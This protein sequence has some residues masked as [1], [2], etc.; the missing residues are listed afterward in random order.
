MLGSGTLGCNLARGLL[1]WGIRH[2]TF[3]DCGNISISNP[4]R[5]SLYT[6][7]DSGKSKAEAAAEA[8]KKI[9]PGVITKGVTMRIPMPGHP[10]GNGMCSFLSIDIEELF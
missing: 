3:V 9:F 2:I 5:Q 8:I 6:A 7:D 10:P 4:I 1:G